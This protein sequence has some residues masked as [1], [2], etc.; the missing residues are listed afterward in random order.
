MNDNRRPQV[1]VIGAGAAGLFAAIFAA[2]TGAHVDLL[3]TRPAPGAKIRVSG[4]GRCNVMPSAVTVDNFKSSGSPNTLRNILHSW[5]RDEVEEFFRTEVGLDMYVE[6]DTGKL[7]PRS[8]QAREVVDRLLAA[9]DRAG[10]ALHVNAKVAT[11]RGAAPD[12]TVNCAD[13]RAFTADRIILATGGLSL[14]RTGSDGH[15][16][17][18]A[19]AQGHSLEATHP[20]LV[21]LRTGHEDWCE[22]AGIAIPT[23]LRAVRDE[24]LLEERPGALL[25]T[26]R[27][28]SGPVVLDLS[29]HV[30]GDRRDTELLASWGDHPDAM[31]EELLAAGGSSRLLR[32]LAE[33][34]PRRLVKLLLARAAVPEDRPLGQLKR[35]ERAAV[36]RQLTRCPLPI[37]GDEGY[38]KAEVTA[39]GIPLSEVN[40]RTLES[41]RCPGLYF[42][43][44]ILDVVGHIGGYNFLW[45]WV[46]GRKAGTAAGQ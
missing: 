19:A 27:G 32:P 26:H 24:R 20:A 2:R 46:T 12:F 41:R 40:P 29:L 9:V 8:N 14:P 3:E 11:L 17:E 13:G 31:W 42:C 25:F 6:A 37:G 7:F 16:F 36:I 1:V 45:A 28:F 44:E 30:T 15:G 35:D 18:L 22:L 33:R 34:L 23:R 5:P 4:G 39:G 21:P 38:A 43:G 10:V